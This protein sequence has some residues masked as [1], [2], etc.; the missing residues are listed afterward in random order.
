MKDPI[1]GIGDTVRTKS[2][3]IKGVVIEIYASGWYPA[4]KMA[5]NDPKAAT[6]F[7]QQFDLEELRGLFV[8]IKQPDGTTWIGPLN[9][10]ELV[11]KK[12]GNP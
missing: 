8:E 2:E 3:H 10:V 6:N 12:R 7:I 4:G 11:E 1:I 5:A 9:S